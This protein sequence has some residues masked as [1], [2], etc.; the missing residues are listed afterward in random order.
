MLANV[1][2]QWEVEC[3]A[4]GFTRRCSGTFPSPVEL[5]CARCGPG[6]GW[7][8]AAVARVLYRIR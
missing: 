6:V 3:L 1:S 2:A 7:W 8:R 5:A 4:C